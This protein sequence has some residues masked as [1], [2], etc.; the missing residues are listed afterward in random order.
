MARFKD[1]INSFLSGEV[2]PKFLG[3]QDSPALKQ[4]CETLLNT[5]VYPQGG[6]G[7]RTGTSIFDSTNFSTLNSARMIPLIISKS[8]AYVLVI[9]TQPYTVDGSN[10][11]LTGMYIVNASTGVLGNIIHQYKG[12]IGIGQ[13]ASVYA[14]IGNFTHLPQIQYAQQGTTLFLAHADFPPFAI[15]I[16][17]TNSF[18]LLDHWAFYE[19]GKDA[20][21]FVL[22]GPQIALGWPFDTRNL[23]STTL[24]AAAA[25]GFNI[26]LTASSAVFDPAQAGSTV[27]ITDPTAAKTGVAI[28]R[29]VTSAT[30]AKIDIIVDFN[31]TTASANWAFSQWSNLRGYPNAVAFFEQRLYYGGNIGYPTGLWASAIG[32]V[33]NFR[34]EHYIDDAPNT[35]NN[36]D[37]Y[38]VN[39]AADKLTSVAW[40]SP[41][42]TLV[43]GTFGREFVGEGPD[44]TQALGPL[45]VGFSAESAYGSSLVQPVRAQDTVRFV[46]RSGEK[47]RELNFN[48]L[49]NNYKAPEL[50]RYAEHCVTKKISITDDLDREINQITEIHHQE[51]DNGI[52]WCLDLCGTVFGIT[53]D[54]D[55]EVNAFHFQKFG[56]VFGNRD[57]AKILSMCVIPSVTVLG[58]HD[59]VWFMVQRTINGVSK[60]YIEIM[61]KA[62]KGDKM[63]NASSLL[64]NKPVYMDS[65]KFYKGSPTATLAVPHLP[66]TQVEV[67]ADGIYRGFFTT[68]GSGNITLPAAVS[69][70]LA[71]LSYRTIIKPV[72]L[73]AGSVVG[74]A[75]G[76][77]K[78][79]DEVTLRFNRTIGAK[80]GPDLNTLQAIDFRNTTV[81]QADPI[82]LYSGDQT[83]KFQAG[84]N[85][86]AYIVV[87][88]DLPLPFQLTSIITR[89]MTS[90]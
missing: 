24:A 61:G 2:S 23:S 37:P 35:L 88:Q 6:A 26:T 11:V 16:L 50:T 84:Y 17:G 39:L 42:K 49:E 31:S 27:R 82:A 69:E 56:G 67:I 73:E 40:L 32:N 10:N 28:I 58:N 53:R 46:T 38:S 29:S 34:Q 3:R 57:E 64:Q 60:T 62:F 36:A 55:L 1:S 76:S 12:G 70:Y 9:T 22:G 85:R 59:D 41:G 68:D 21:S 80:F 66:N 8:Q 25:T 18:R 83:Y 54:K 20:S 48:I 19:L 75:Q 5:I 90:D 74:S 63:L 89:G 86:S 72:N 4:A 14:G 45:N 65:C 15:E 47:I 43:I 7:R 52:T 77:M 81:G 79:I 78:K 44:N 71:G 13:H 87:V 30:V 33:A 51:A